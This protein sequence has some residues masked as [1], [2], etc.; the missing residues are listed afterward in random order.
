MKPQPPD[1][2]TA[3]K[4]PAAD[5]PAEEW[6]RLAVSIPGWRWMPG[7]H[8]AW[9]DDPRTDVEGE[10]V[11]DPDDPATAGCLLALLGDP[12]TRVFWYGIN[13][14]VRVNIMPPKGERVFIAEHGERGF[15]QP[16]LG[17]ACIAAANA[18]GR[19]P[20]GG[21]DSACPDCGGSIPE[22][23]HHGYDGPEWRCLDGRWPGGDS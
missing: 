12:L 23:Q 3:L 17:R 2:M 9:G 11:P 1:R 7:M 6:G 4:T 14:T 18:L 22:H 21:S 15:N 10:S 20:G 8:W 13:V 5:A 16:T 19:W